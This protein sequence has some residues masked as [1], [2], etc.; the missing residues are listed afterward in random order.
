MVESTKTNEQNAAQLIQQQADEELESFMLSAS[1]EFADLNGL[2][3]T[4][5][6]GSSVYFKMGGVNY[7]CDKRRTPA[8]KYVLYITADVPNRK[9]YHEAVFDA[10]TKRLKASLFLTAR[11]LFDML[12][13]L[14]AKHAELFDN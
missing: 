13:I 6:V 14:N 10:K 8:E 1:C 7:C 2:L 9:M 4:K 12:A 11:Q 3:K 5:K